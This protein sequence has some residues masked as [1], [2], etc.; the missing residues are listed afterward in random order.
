VGQITKGQRSSGE[1]DDSYANMGYCGGGSLRTL[2]SLR[3]GSLHNAWLMRYICPGCERL[4]EPAETR[5]VGDAIEI[6]C[7]RCSEVETLD[8]RAAPRQEATKEPEPDLPEAELEAEASHCPKCGGL[9]GEEAACTRCGLVYEKW[10]PD[11]D[12]GPS[13]AL[14]EA[15]D[16]LEQS[17]DD[18][19]LHGK[20]VEACL[21]AGQLPF[22]AKRYGSRQ[23]AVAREQLKL[24][25]AMAFHAM[26]GAESTG[27]PNIK[28]RRVVGWSL[29][30]AVFLGIIGFLLYMYQ[31]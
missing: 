28:A 8:L 13:A 14:V 30:I 1:S 7:P 2:L 5:A 31:R 21:V 20:F 19:G 12:D 11:G 22:A 24:L 17:W 6:S 15:W 3:L 10:D 9:R 26:R 25:T 29:L 27:Q 18:R 4:V 23:D 16:E